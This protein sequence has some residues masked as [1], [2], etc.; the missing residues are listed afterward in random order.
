MNSHNYVG[1]SLFVINLDFYF[2]PEVAFKE[3]QELEHL[4]ANFNNLGHDGRMKI[5]RLKESISRNQLSSFPEICL[6]PI[7]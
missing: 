3:E 7:K 1:S 4:K 5:E 6:P 2:Q